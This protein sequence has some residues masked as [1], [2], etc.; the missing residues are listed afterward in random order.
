MR[1]V[2]LLLA[3]VLAATP[4][5]AQDKPTATSGEHRGAMFWSGIALGMHFPVDVLGGL[6]LGWLSVTLVRALITNLY[7][8]V[9]GKRLQTT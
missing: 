9:K 6:L 3:L 8:V 5:F 1:S 7:G 2:S 4:A